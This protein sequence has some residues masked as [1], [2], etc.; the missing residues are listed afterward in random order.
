MAIKNT[1]K[2][3]AHAASVHFYVDM[4]WTLAKNV[5]YKDTF[6]TER[7]EVIAKKFLKQ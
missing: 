7:Q 1:L 6:L 5:L 4:L 3:E 2:D